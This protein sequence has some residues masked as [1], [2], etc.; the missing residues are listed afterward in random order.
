MPRTAAYAQSIT[1]T[2]GSTPRAN[3]VRVSSRRPAATACARGHAPVTSA[4]KWSATLMSSSANAPNTRLGCDAQQR[5]LPRRLVRPP[6]RRKRP[7]RALQA[8]ILSGSWSRTTR[9]S[10]VLPSSVASASRP[11]LSNQTARRQIGVHDKVCEQARALRL[12]PLSRR[13]CKLLDY[14]LAQS[15]KRSA[16]VRYYS[17][18]RRRASPL[19][20]RASSRG[21]GS[22]DRA[23][24]RYSSVRRPRQNPLPAAIWNCQAARSAEFSKRLTVSSLTRAGIGWQSSAHCV[25]RH[26]PGL[27]RACMAPVAR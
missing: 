21:A 2:C 16:S 20:T 1:R 10:G 18:C 14:V 13:T 8:T 23:T 26:R 5:A 4:T 27:P 6:T 24:R 7:I 22:P 25:R 9:S 17:R 3:R 15:A 19:P 12:R 11:W